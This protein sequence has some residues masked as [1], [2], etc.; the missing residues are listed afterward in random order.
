MPV[1]NTSALAALAVGLGLSSSVPA[2]A[3]TTS[4]DTLPQPPIAAITTVRPGLLRDVVVRPTDFNQDASA[5]QN[6]PHDSVLNG[7]LIGAGAGALLGLIPDYYDDCEECH[8]SLYWSIAVGAGVGVLVD[9]LKRGKPVPSPAVAHG[10]LRVDL[11]IGKR[12]A[13][14]NA[15]IRW[16]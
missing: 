10:P 16:R 5:K 14:V 1:W 15:T 13:G 7:L 3:Q 4:H 8:D 2:A 12:R 9:L 11:A 6:Q